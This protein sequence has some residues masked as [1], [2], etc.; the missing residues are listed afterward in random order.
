MRVEKES[1]KANVSFVTC[2]RQHVTDG[3]SQGG[4]REIP[5]LHFL[6]ILIL[7]KNGNKLCI[8]LIHVTLHSLATFSLI[9]TQNVHCEMCELRLKKQLIM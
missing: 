8:I 6:H 4:F 5:F 7:L 1:V 9:F 3:I 2:S